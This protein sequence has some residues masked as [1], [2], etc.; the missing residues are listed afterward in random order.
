MH[1]TEVTNKSSILAS[2]YLRQITF[3]GVYVTRLL[4]ILNAYVVLI[5]FLS[6]LASD[7]LCYLDHDAHLSQ[8]R[9]YPIGP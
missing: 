5:G 6:L 3:S 9:F 1:C 4:S 7:D 2:S 8:F